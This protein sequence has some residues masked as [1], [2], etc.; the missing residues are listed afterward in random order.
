MITTQLSTNAVVS[1]LLL[2]SV[3][4]LTVTYSYANKFLNSVTLYGSLSK[5]IPIRF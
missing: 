4:T 3:N 1:F 5:P 2:L